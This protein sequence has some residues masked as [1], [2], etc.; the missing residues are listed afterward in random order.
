M[1][2][3]KVI[4][5]TL[6]AAEAM[7]SIEANVAPVTS[8]YTIINTLKSFVQPP[9]CVVVR[10]NVYRRNVRV[11]N[12]ITADQLYTAVQLYIVVQEFTTT[13]YTAFTD[14]HS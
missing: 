12:L 14:T 9:R 7:F 1:K 8:E 3:L 11:V 4:L 5:A 13:G 2:P 10:R 6:I